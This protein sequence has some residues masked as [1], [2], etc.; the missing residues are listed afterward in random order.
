M[1]VYISGRNNFKGVA[2]L[3]RPHQV[4]GTG[5]IIAKREVVPSFR[6]LLAV[7]AYNHRARARGHQH[8][9]AVFESSGCAVE[10][11]RLKAK[12]ISNYRN[13]TQRHRGAGNNGTQQQ[14]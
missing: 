11:R 9:N 1:R 8:A 5:T 7:S 14:A 3:A 13:G 2:K 6:N 10:F 12:C 4:C